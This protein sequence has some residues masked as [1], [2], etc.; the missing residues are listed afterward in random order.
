M[1]GMHLLRHVKGFSDEQ[2]R[3]QWLENLRFQALCGE[4]S[5][6]HVLPLDPLLNV[7]MARAD[8]RPLRHLAATPGRVRP[9]SARSVA[10]AGRLKRTWTVVDG[11]PHGRGGK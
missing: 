6:Q 5:F 3:A 2:V 11:M 4:T 8:P 1:V 7:T 10:G 9:P